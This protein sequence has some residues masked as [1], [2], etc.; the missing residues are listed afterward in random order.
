MLDDQI[1]IGIVGT[2]YA[3]KLRAESFGRDE[4]SRV[5]AIT[6]HTPEKT[7]T[8]SQTYQAQAVDSWQQLVA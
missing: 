8:F 3:A 5:V 7:A 2:G 6:G 4:R 1:Q